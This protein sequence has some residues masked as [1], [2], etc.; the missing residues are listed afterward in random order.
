[1]LKT[2]CPQSAQNIAHGSRAISLDETV[3]S[4]SVMA[5]GLEMTDFFSML[6]KMAVSGPFQETY[7]YAYDFQYTLKPRFSMVKKPSLRRIRW[8]L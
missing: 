2:A 6:W 1:M 3:G 7:R 4:E 8:A 5:S